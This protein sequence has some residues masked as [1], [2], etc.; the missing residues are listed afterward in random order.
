[1]SKDH[2][3]SFNNHTV[4]HTLSGKS[5]IFQEVYQELLEFIAADPNCDYKIAV[6]TDSHVRRDTL[7]VSCILIHRVGKGAKGYYTKN[8][9]HRPIYSLRE[10][11]YTETTATYSIA[12]LFSQERIAKISNLLK[13]VG[14]GVDFEFHIDIG[15][16]GPTKALINEIVGMVR[17]IQFIPKIKPDSYCASTFADRKTK[18]M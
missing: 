2:L 6:G 1:M 3:I 10:K 4:F 15:E 13:N 5:L 17:G 7:F 16:K 18:A 12:L 8:L 14:K 9:I 11:I